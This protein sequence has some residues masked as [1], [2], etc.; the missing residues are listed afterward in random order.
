MPK[1][2]SKGME[3]IKPP[4]KEIFK[5]QIASSQEL[6]SLEEI[7]QVG[8][9]AGIT[10]TLR[11]AIKALMYRYEEVELRILRH[12]LPGSYWTVAKNLVK[13]I[14]QGEEYTVQ[15]TRETPWLIIQVG[16]GLRK[17]KYIQEVMR[18]LQTCNQVD[19]VIATMPGS[20][21]KQPWQFAAR[22]NGN[23]IKVKV[24]KFPD[25]IRYQRVEKLDIKQ[26][27]TPRI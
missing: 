3:R 26:C 2:L 18:A 5:I 17:T 27:N 4:K 8:I 1:L 7:A 23:G 11:A 14:G 9:H 24:Y 12:V 13:H 19:C 6:A 15:A 10:P 20:Y 25:C 22:L 21:A 16:Y